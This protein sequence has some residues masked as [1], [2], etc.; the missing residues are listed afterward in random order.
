MVWGQITWA[1]CS[2][3]LR[4]QLRPWSGSCGKAPVDTDF[5]VQSRAGSARIHS[6]GV[7]RYGTTVNVRS[8][9]SPP[10]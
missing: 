7:S 1:G 6:F 2:A 3:P 4:A 9:A 10:W 5:H 8:F